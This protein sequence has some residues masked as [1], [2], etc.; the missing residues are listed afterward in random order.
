MGVTGSLT[1]DG[2]AKMSKS[3]LTALSKK[4]EEIPL[5]LLSIGAR[6]AVMEPSTTPGPTHENGTMLKRELN[7]PP[8]SR[9]S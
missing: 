5:S 2:I 3:S 8:L 1:D 6:D 4:A 7:Y 9:D